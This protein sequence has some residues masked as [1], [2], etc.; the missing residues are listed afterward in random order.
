M[1]AALRVAQV[2]RQTT[3]TRLGESSIDNCEDCGRYIPSLAIETDMLLQ[4]TSDN[5]GQQDARL[6]I[7]VALKP[8]QSIWGNT[9]I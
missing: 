4:P 5:V 2:R 7:S 6:V 8:Y 9:G 1:R 3:S